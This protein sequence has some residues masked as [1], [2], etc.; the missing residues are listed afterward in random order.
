MRRREGERRRREIMCIYSIKRERNKPTIE[1]WTL[2]NLGKEYMEVHYV[3]LV[4]FYK[5]EI[6][7]K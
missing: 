5:T 6:C 7:S 2:V 4:T 1:K 3:I